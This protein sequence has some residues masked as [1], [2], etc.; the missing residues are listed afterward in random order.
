MHPGGPL[1]IGR[2]ISGR[3]DEGGWIAILLQELRKVAFYF[4]QV[5]LNVYVNASCPV[6]QPPDQT[7][8]ETG[9]MVGLK[10]KLVVGVGQFS[11]DVD[12]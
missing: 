10:A 6:I 9:L 2:W 4:L 1:H 8:F 12:V 11:V 3:V 7:S 5:V